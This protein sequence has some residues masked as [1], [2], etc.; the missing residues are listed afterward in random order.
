MPHIEIVFCCSDPKQSIHTHIGTTA[1]EGFFPGGG[2]IVDFS[3]GA[4]KIFPEGEK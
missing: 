4:K 2:A 3:K 1:S